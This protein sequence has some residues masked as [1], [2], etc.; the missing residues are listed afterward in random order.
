VEILY[1]S[2][3]FDNI[4]ESV[5]IE[6]SSLSNRGHYIQ[7]INMTSQ[8]DDN[9]YTIIGVGLTQGIKLVLSLKNEVKKKSRG[10]GQR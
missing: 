8:K 1:N 3:S 5:D 6:V 7:L 10:G 9:Q 4:F 2:S